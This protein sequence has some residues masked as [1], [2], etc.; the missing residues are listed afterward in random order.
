MAYVSSFVYA[1]QIRRQRT[2][3]GDMRNEIINPLQR[4]RLISVPSNFSFILSCVI[5]DFEVGKEHTIKIDFLD[6]HDK[7]IATIADL[8]VPANLSPEKIEKINGI[9]LDID[10]RNFIFR[11]EG[12]YL[13]KIYFDDIMIGENKIPVISDSEVSHAK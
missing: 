13:T 6:P 2:K 11:E 9:Q 7:I 12:N 5:S 10:V 1:E 3:E 4:L 8:K